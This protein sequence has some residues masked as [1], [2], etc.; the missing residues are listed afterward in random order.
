[1]F[2]EV[3][4]LTRGLSRRARGERTNGRKCSVSK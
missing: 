1:M 2:V 4:T 3:K